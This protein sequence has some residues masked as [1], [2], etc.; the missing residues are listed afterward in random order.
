MTEQ[1]Y[2]IIQIATLIIFAVMVLGSLREA[3][4]IGAIAMQ[5]WREAIRKKTL[6]LVM[7]FAVVLIASTTFVQ[8]AGADVVKEERRLRVMLE[9]SFRVMSLFTILCAIFLTSFSLPSD[10]SQRQIFTLLSKPISRWGLLTGKILGF[11]LLSFVMLVMM[12]VFTVLTLKITSGRAPAKVKERLL[13]AREIVRPAT[14]K[15]M[16]WRNAQVMKQ[17]VQITMRPEILRGSMFRFNTGPQDKLPGEK[18]V[19]VRF[20]FQ[21]FRNSEGEMR[22]RE[23]ELT[24]AHIVFDLIEPISKERK[25]MTIPLNPENGISEV[26][27]VNRSFFTSNSFGI[28]VIRIAP[29]TRN[30]GSTRFLREGETGQWEF[31]HL[32]RSAL[33]VDGQ[34]VGDKH[35]TVQVQFRIVSRGGHYAGSKKT[36]LRFYYDMPEEKRKTVVVKVRDARVATMNIPSEAIDKTGKLVL[37]LENPL[38]TAYFYGYDNQQYG[39]ALLS[40]PSSFEFNVFKA[41]VMMSFQVI[42]L[43]V[44]TVS[45]STFLSWPITALTSL[46]VY[47]C[48]SIINFI[49]EMIAAGEKSGSFL[50]NQAHDHGHAAGEGLTLFDKLI[51]AVLQLLRLIMPDMTQ[52][53]PLSLIGQGYSVSLS[54]LVRSFGYMCI[55]ATIALAI[56]WSIFRRRSVD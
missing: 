15:L 34:A 27:K 33:E 11:C 29:E 35:V 1:L 49:G 43:V 47:F 37:K 17:G 12:A 45:A 24:N 50:G 8:A 44:V 30:V 52:F 54:E 55:F 21:H 4:G 19:P 38:R 36:E 10:I 25:R 53:S 46:F 26:F 5:T 32:K 6:W 51:T 20:R 28:E 48:G 39:V 41:V 31:K 18:E 13:G 3:R 14:F 40:R 23:E 56:G 9:I 7:L 42:L 22:Y 16:A 2:W